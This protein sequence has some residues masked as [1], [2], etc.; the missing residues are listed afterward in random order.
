[1][2]A[3]HYVTGMAPPVGASPHETAA[4]SKKVLKLIEQVY[5]VNSANT[6]QAL[7]LLNP[8]QLYRGVA[9]QPQEWWDALAK[10]AGANS[11]STET[12]AAV[13]AHFRARATEAA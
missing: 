9:A 6:L 4:R 11:P 13:V 7:P 10:Q 8:A 2:A 1:M 3:G 12:I 5:R